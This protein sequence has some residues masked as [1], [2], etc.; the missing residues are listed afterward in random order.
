MPS[1][2]SSSPVS[3]GDIFYNGQI[4][5]FTPSFTLPFE[6]RRRRLPLRTLMFEEEEERETVKIDSSNELYG[7]AEGTYC[8]WTPPC[9]RQAPCPSAGRFEIFCLGESQ[10]WLLKVFII[11]SSSDWTYL[12]RWTQT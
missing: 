7:V 3:A 2:D 1:P 9:K 8:V 12:Y 10:R 11:E 5:P 6:P 4:R